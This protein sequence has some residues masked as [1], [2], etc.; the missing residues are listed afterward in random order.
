M[1]VIAEPLPRN[2][3]L[4]AQTRL[5][6]R[7]RQEEPPPSDRDRQ[8][9][10]ARRPK[11]QHALSAHALLGRHDDP[12]AATVLVLTGGLVLRLLQ[13]ILVQA[14]RVQ[15]ED[16]FEQGAGDEGGGEMGGQVV[17]EEELAAHDEERDVV[18]GPAEEKET[19][20]VV[21]TGAGS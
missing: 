4:R 19:S 16:E 14:G 1:Q 20:A 13:E 9:D 10:R 2:D 12:L 18:G 7:Q 17:V 5:P 15:V 6:V 11:R 8:D 21:E 3:L